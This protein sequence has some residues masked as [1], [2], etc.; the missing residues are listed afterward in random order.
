MKIGD[1]ALKQKQSYIEIHK[2]KLIRSCDLQTAEG[3]KL[4]IHILFNSVTALTPCEDIKPC[5]ITTK[6]EN[7]PSPL[8]LTPPN[9]MT[10]WLMRPV[11][12]PTMPTSNASATL[13]TLPTSLEKKYPANPNG[14]LFANLMTSSSVSN[15]VKAASGP[16]V[17]S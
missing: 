9:G 14:V 10:A 6:V 3:D 13:Q 7:V 2:L 5:K 16:N 1:E 17:S 12:V 11:L 15:L 8:S 4:D